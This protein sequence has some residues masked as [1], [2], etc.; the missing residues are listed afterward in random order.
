[1]NRS[2]ENGQIPGGMESLSYLKNVERD[3]SLSSSHS[4]SSRLQVSALLLVVLLNDD[5]ESINVNRFPGIIGLIDDLLSVCFQSLLDAVRTGS[6]GSVS[7]KSLLADRCK[8]KSIVFVPIPNKSHE[9]LPVYRCGNIQ[10]YFDRNVVFV[11]QN[12]GVTWAPQSLALTL[13]MAE[14]RN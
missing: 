7:L 9:G 2:V 10:V 4:A 6:Q 3:T 14:K 13:D 8:E 11:S 1:M 12:R 5:D